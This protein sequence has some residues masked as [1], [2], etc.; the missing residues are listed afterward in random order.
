MRTLRCSCAMWRGNVSRRRRRLAEIVRQHRIAR[1]QR[2]RRARPPN[3]APGTRARPCRPRDDAPAAAARRTARRLPAAAPPARR[4]RATRR[5]CATAARSIRPRASSCQ[6]RSGASVA[7]SP[8]ATSSRISASVSGA[9]TKPNRAAKRAT[10]S[11]RSG[12]SANAGE[13][14]RSTPR[15][16]IRRAAERIDQRAVLAARHRVDRDVAT[17]QVLF[18]RHVGRGEELEAAIAAAVLALG[19][20]E[21]VL[22]VRVGMQE[23]GKVAADRT[24]AGRQH[25]LGRRAHHDVVVIGH[26]RGRGARR[27]PIR[28][29]GTRAPAAEAAAPSASRSAAA[30]GAEAGRTDCAARRAKDTTARP[31]RAR[32]ARCRTPR[33]RTVAHVVLAASTAGCRGS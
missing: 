11:T 21:R 3:P 4:I 25:D 18:E 5:S 22:L 1:W 10:R 16:E 31:L 33:E 9:T 13:T 14:W 17:Q 2:L 23:D 26:R 7:S 20:R 30:G 32:S 27:A 15:C 12:S 24:K 29:P 6:T 8:E 28:R 19:S